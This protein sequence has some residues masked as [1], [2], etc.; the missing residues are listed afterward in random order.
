MG[1]VTEADALIFLLTYCTRQKLTTITSSVFTVL[2]VFQHPFLASSSD[3]SAELR[4]PPNGI[5]LK[6]AAEGHTKERD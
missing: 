5:I 4:S 2:K 3:R 6:H 1:F